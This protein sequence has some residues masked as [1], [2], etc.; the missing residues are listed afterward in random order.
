MYM[1]SY[2]H[3]Y[4]FLK[5]RKLISA[6]PRSSKQRTCRC[7]SSSASAEAKRAS[8]SSP[9]AAGS[10][11]A[12]AASFRI[13]RMWSIKLSEETPAG[14]P[15]PPSDASAALVGAWDSARQRRDGM[16]PV[17]RR[18]SAAEDMA[19]PACESAVS[20][21]PC[22]C[23]CTC[24][25]TYMRSYVYVYRYAYVRRRRRSPAS[26]RGRAPRRRRCK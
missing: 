20:T 18:C 13:E 12:S 17:S 2:A 15:P 10:V 4:V 24:A 14:L 3:V 25:H 21:Q 8:P 23:I 6:C 22:I 19:R 26:R 5:A 9:S 16:A 11:S 7:T 1:C